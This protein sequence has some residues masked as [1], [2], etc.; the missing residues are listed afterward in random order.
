M[1]S[2]KRRDGETGEAQRRDGDGRD[3]ISLVTPW[4]TLPSSLYQV[5]APRNQVGAADGVREKT[6]A[7]D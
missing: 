3:V 2:W 4:L 6:K 7:A 1:L 5:T